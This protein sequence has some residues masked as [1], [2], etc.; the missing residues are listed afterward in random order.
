MKEVVLG[1]LALFAWAIVMAAIPVGICYACWC[2][3]PV[4]GWI[5][6][7]VCA[8]IVFC[9]ASQEPL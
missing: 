7:A 9:D 3:H 1:L 2:F 8:L 6:I 4:I 5:A